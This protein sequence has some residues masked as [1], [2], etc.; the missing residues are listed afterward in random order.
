[1]KLD[2][3]E[4][5]V[6]VV[7]FTATAADWAAEMITWKPAPDDTSPPNLVFELHP[8][9]RLGGK[10]LD[11]GGEPIAGAE[12]EIWIWAQVS[13]LTDK[14]GKPDFSRVTVT[15]GADGYWEAGGIPGN[16]LHQMG[17]RFLHNSFLGQEY[18]S[19]ASEPGLER[20]LRTKRHEIRLARGQM[21]KGVVLDFEKAGFADLTAEVS[22]EEKDEPQAV[23]LHPM[24]VIEGEAVDAETGQPVVSFRVMQGADATWNT[25]LQA[26]DQPEG[27]FRITMKPNR[28][29]PLRVASANHEPWEFDVANILPGLNH[30][31]ARLK[32]VT[33]LDGV[34]VNAA[35]EPVEGVSLALAGDRL[36]I[37]VRE[38][39]PQSDNAALA[40]SDAEGHFHLQ[41]LPDPVRVLG[42]HPRGVGNVPWEEFMLRKGVQWGGG[43]AATVN[44]EAFGSRPLSVAPDGTFQAGDLPAGTYKLYVG[45]TRPITPAELEE[46]KNAGHSF[47]GAHLIRLSVAEG[48]M[49]FTVPSSVPDVGTFDVGEAPLVL[50]PGN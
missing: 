36:G 14:G 24:T 17:L 29:D 10:V 5:G 40:T 39:Q 12:V 33:G 46:L 26:V 45:G 27:H 7:E 4:R 50:M 11:E 6:D 37:T 48:R 3:P 9:L 44:P 30:V 25:T 47:P 34:V 32:R 20:A 16:F 23:V 22:L 28:D 43:V 49:E 42:Y 1:M 2:V 31:V 38:G 13:L 18:F 21:V 19:I 41:P 35:G 15:T 8:A